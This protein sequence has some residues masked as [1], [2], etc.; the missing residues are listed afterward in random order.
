MPGAAARERPGRRHRRL[1]LR[2]QLRLHLGRRHP[3]GRLQQ[4]LL[5]DRGG[6]RRHQRPRRARRLRERQ[7][8]RLPARLGGLPAVARAGRARAGRARVQPKPTTGV[9]DRDSLRGRGVS[10]GLL[11]EAGEAADGAGDGVWD[12]GEEGRAADGRS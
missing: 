6:R 7:R 3:R 11:G 12:G 10:S 2:A 9:A 5:A 8:R 4:P 1:V